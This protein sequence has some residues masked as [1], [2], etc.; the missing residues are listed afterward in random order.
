MIPPR[1]IGNEYKK[2]MHFHL[3][4]HH[5]H[6]SSNES[7]TRSWF[8]HEPCLSGANQAL[9]TCIQL[10]ILGFF[11][12]FFLLSLILACGRPENPAREGGMG[13]GTGTTVYT[14]YDP[15]YG[16]I[17]GRLKGG[18]GWGFFF[19]FFPLYL[20]RAGCGAEW[21]DF[22]VVVDRLMIPIDLK[23]PMDPRATLGVARNRKNH[24]RTQAQPASIYIPHTFSPSFFFQKQKH[25]FRPSEDAPPV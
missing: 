6:H 11:F 21:S 17:D 13:N 4:H 9:G 14:H 15:T 25:I 8:L 3:H 19:L 23:I 2:N 1:H 20:M 24:V 7:L 5:H 18:L 22:V 10:L 12:F 16:F